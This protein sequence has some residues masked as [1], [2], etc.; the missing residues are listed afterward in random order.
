MVDITE[1]SAVVVAGGVLVGVIY[2]IL[3]MRNQTKQRE[4]QVFLQLSSYMGNFAQY[5]TEFI[6]LYK[7]DSFEDYWK[8]YGPE[9]NPE[10]W[11]KQFELYGFYESLGILVKKKLLD[12]NFVYDLIGGAVEGY[13]KK[14]KPITEGLRKRWGPAWLENMEFLVNE[15]ETIRTKRERMSRQIV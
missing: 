1:I 13:W 2:Y 11:K 3:D 5:Y 4:T 6:W 9:T 14:A 15:L 7:F 8:K 12:V 10:E